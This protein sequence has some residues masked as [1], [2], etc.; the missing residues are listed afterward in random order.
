[1]GVKGSACLLCFLNYFLKRCAMRGM[2]KKMRRLIGLA[3]PRQTRSCTCCQL[4]STTQCAKE[5]GNVAT[6]FLLKVHLSLH[7]ILPSFQP[8]LE[9]AKPSPGLQRLPLPAPVPLLSWRSCWLHPWHLSWIV[10]FSLAC[11]CSWGILGR[12]GTVVN[13]MWLNPN[14][15]LLK[16]SSFNGV[17]D[18]CVFIH[19]V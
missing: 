6:I 10:L 13:E 2:R 8:R 11:C 3:C 9:P 5:P 12:F 14:Q 17:K 19:S 4:L 16:L 7:V 15:F 18:F 1:M